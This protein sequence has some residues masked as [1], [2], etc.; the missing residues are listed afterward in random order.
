MVL[1]VVDC[2]VELPK[3]RERGKTVKFASRFPASKCCCGLMAQSDLE[4]V[5]FQENMK[6]YIKYYSQEEND[7]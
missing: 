1:P 4:N 3:G 2:K 7:Q 6:L 5:Q